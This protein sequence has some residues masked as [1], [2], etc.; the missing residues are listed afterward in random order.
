MFKFAKKPDQPGLSSSIRSKVMME[1]TKHMQIDQPPP[2]SN[3]HHKIRQS[4]KFPSQIY[5]PLF[6][7]LSTHITGLILKKSER[8]NVSH[9]GHRGFKP[10]QVYHWPLLALGRL[11]CLHYTRH[12]RSLQAEKPTV[13]RRTNA[14][15]GRIDQKSD[16]KSASS[17]IR[18]LRIWTVPLKENHFRSTSKSS[19]S[20]SSRQSERGSG[21]VR[22]SVRLSVR[23]FV[24]RFLNAENEPFSLWK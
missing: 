8:G 24:T 6:L 11:F 2:P 17:W 9:I 12:R 1:R 23:R 13:L 14:T 18:T 22:W 19:Y 21:R 10:C 16:I 7:R 4:Q 20:L 15:D 5:F 3:G